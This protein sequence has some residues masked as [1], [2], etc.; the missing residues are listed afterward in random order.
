MPSQH[1]DD[2]AATAPETGFPYTIA[3]FQRVNRSAFRK[4]FREFV[5]LCRQIDLVGRVARCG[6]HAHH[7]G[8]QQRPQF[9]PFR[10]V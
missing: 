3:T 5:V 4:V 10:S 2:L 8:Q 6:R 1:R 9:Y 7:G